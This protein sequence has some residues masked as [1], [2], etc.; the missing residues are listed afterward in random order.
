MATRPALRKPLVVWVTS[1]ADGTE[2]AVNEEQVTPARAGVYAT[3]CG[4]RM[5]AATLATHEL[6]R[7]TACV[8][9]LHPQP[10]RHRARQRRGR[11]G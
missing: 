4:V 5:I 11:R 6:R 7:C 2:H 8:R 1:G 9:Q 10:G 3:R